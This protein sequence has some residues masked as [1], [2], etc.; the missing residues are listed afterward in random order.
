MVCNVIVNCVYIYLYVNKLNWRVIWFNSFIDLCFWLIYFS[1]VKHRIPSPT[2]EAGDGMEAGKEFSS[3]TKSSPRSVAE[4]SVKLIKLPKTNISL[5]KLPPITDDK[6]KLP[7]TEPTSPLVLVS[8]L[9]LL[10][11]VVFLYKKLYFTPYT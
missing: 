5:S 1:V 11:S 7:V 6:V 8:F 10:K 3:S 2:R 9:T 4:E